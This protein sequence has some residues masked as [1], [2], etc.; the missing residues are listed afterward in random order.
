MWRSS[1]G[2]GRHRIYNSSMIRWRP[3]RHIGSGNPI[4]NQISWLI[5]LIYISFKSTEMNK[6]FM[7][8]SMTWQMHEKLRIRP[9]LSGKGMQFKHKP[10][11]RIMK[12][13]IITSV[14]SISFWT[15]CIKFV[16]DYNTSICLTAWPLVS[17]YS[18]PWILAIN[19]L[20]PTSKF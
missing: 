10:S 15:I 11:R 8:L 7:V 12:K 9:S 20:P 6:L 13:Q 4:V 17:C 5:Q 3:C 18:E 19:C 2:R 16:Y 1:S 14:F